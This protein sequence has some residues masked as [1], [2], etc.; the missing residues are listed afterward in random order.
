MAETSD[1]TLA[2][3]F[4]GG[5]IYTGLGTGLQIFSGIVATKILTVF[6]P[7]SD[8]GIF[9]LMELVASFL[10]MFSDFRL[11][12]AAICEL[13]DAQAE[14][15]RVIVDTVTIFR[16]ATV[17]LI[18]PLFFAAQQWVYKLLGG[19]SVGNLAFLIPAFTLVEA[20]RRVLKELLQGFFR[21]KQM[22]I[23]ELGASI[24]RVIS[25]AVMLIWLKTGLV[26]A[27]LA[28]LVAT[29]TTCVLFYVALP[30]KKGLSF[31]YYT[32]VRMLRFSWP[33]QINEI[34][35]FIFS[36]FGTLVV[37]TLMTPAAVASLTVASRIPSNLIRLYHSFRVVYFPNLVGLISRGDRRRAQKMLNATLRLIAF[38]MSLASVVALIF[39]KEIILLFFSEQYLAVGPV[40]VLMMLSLTIS[41]AG[42]QLGYSTVAAGDSRAPAISNVV[43]AAVTVISN[44][45][46]IPRLGISGAVLANIAGAVVTNPISVWFLRRTGLIPRVMNYVKPILLFVTIYG[47]FWWLQPERLPVRLLFL[48]AFVIGSFLLRIVTPHDVYGLGNILMSI[49]AKRARRAWPWQVTRG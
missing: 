16:L 42:Y 11:G 40:F 32:L 48:L 18:T 39:Q 12:T 26:G 8:F 38:L 23:I 28:Y 5:T 27:V 46:L 19:E 20:Y 25:L 31:R 3:R 44:L 17:L 49:W 6:L 13:A 21:F 30:T 34:L 35:T 2:S 37:A 14:E 33:L 41:L 7:S 22:A 43:N 9:I 24:L 29:G 1:N 15:Q 47:A 10:A 36:S 45:T 4:I